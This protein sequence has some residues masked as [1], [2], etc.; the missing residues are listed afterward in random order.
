MRVKIVIKF[1][2]LVHFLLKCV[3]FSFL[4]AE[5]GIRPVGLG[6][7]GGLIYIL[8]NSNV[9]IMNFCVFLYTF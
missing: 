3:I 2:F 7:W 1:N 5:D 6:V 9:H 8:V 4:K